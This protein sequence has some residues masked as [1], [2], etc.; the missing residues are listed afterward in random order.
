MNEITP[1]LIV[2]L[3]EK[4]RRAKPFY[5]ESERLLLIAAANHLP[6]LLDEIERLWAEIARLKEENR[7]ITHKLTEDYHYIID[8]Y[9]KISQLEA[10]IQV[11]GTKLDIQKARIAELEAAQRWIPVKDGLPTHAKRVDVYMLNGWQAKATYYE[12]NSYTFWKNDSG[13]I[14]ENITHW[15]PMPPPPE[16]EE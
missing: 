14:I 15:R 7:Q 10:Y 12:Y 8:P 4:I 13:S 11:I 1:E 5:P 3:R 6:F 9:A 16:S 2:E